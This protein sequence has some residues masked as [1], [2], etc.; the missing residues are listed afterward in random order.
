MMM[1]EFADSEEGLEHFV[2]GLY[3]MISYARLKNSVIQT[4]M[5]KKHGYIFTWEQQTQTI[6]MVCVVRKL[7]PVWQ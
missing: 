1:W 3:S 7:M 5:V 2:K 6:L 4:D